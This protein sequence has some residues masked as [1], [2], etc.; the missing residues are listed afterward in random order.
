MAG[1]R[2]AFPVGADCVWKLIPYDVKLPVTICPRIKISGVIK[3]SLIAKPNL[4]QAIE[5]FDVYS[6]YNQ[7]KIV[8]LGVALYCIGKL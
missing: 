2:S 3:T 1:Y 4:A 7:L 5:Y 8:I 6:Q